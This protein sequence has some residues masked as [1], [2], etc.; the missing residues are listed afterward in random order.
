M[1]KQSVFMIV[2]LC[3]I[4]QISQASQRIFVSGADP[5]QIK[6]LAGK[7]HLDILNYKPARGVDCIADSEAIKSI[8]QS[9]YSIQ[10][11]VPDVEAY[12]TQKL[13]NYKYDFGQYYTY[14]EMVKELNSIHDNY[15][16]ITSPPE[17]IGQTGEGRPIW[18]LKINQRYGHNDLP[19][20]LL[21]GVHHACEPIGCTICMGL[22]KYFCQNYGKDS[23]STWLVNNRNLWF[24]PVVNPD[25]YVFN[26][27]NPD[28]MWR[29]N[30]RDNGG[31][32]HGVDL[33]RN[34]PYMWGYNNR[35]SSPDSSDDIY[36]GPS[37]GSEQETQA[38]MNLAVREGSFVTS[39]HYHA[40]ASNSFGHAW[41]YDNVFNPD[42]ALFYDLSQEIIFLSGYHYEAGTG[43]N[44]DVR[45][46]F[47]GEQS[48]KPKCFAYLVEV[49]NDFWEAVSDTNI[50]IQQ[51]G[52]NLPIALAVAKAAGPFVGMAEKPVIGGGNGNGK[53]DPGETV[54]LW[55]N[56]RNKSLETSVANVSAVLSSDDP[57]LEILQPVA[58]FG[59]LTPR[60]AKTNQD[61]PF[62]VRCD[63]AC[64]GGYIAGLKVKY[65]TDHGRFPADTFSLEIG[66][67]PEEVILN[68]DCESGAG[69][70]S[71]GGNNDQ[72]HVSARDSHTPSHS[73]YSGMEGTGQYKDTMDC[74]LA[75]GALQAT[76]FNKLE[77]WTRYDLEPG[78]DLG[79]AEISTD[80]GTDWQQ[81]GPAYTGNVVWNHQS[82]DLSS[83]Y[84]T[85]N[86]AFRMHSDISV[87][88]YEGWCIDDV[89][90]TGT[91]DTNKAPARPVA[92]MPNKDTVD[93]SRP[94][95]IVGKCGD[96]NGN[97]IHYGFKVYSDSL[98]CTLAASTD[99][100]EADTIWQVSPPL[101]QGRYWWRAY[102]DDGR[103]RGLY[104]APRTFY[105]TNGITPVP[106]KVPTSYKLSRCYPNPAGNLVVITYQ[107]PQ[108]GPLEIKIYN[109]TGQ[110]V[111]RLYEGVQGPGNFSLIWNLK[112]DGGK[113]ILSGIYICQLSSVGYHGFQKITV[114][115][116][117][118][119]G[120]GRP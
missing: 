92:V 81:I 117:G 17:A 15:P 60:Q 62:L 10:I 102:A 25:G 24:V 74:R 99:S 114:L 66:S 54:E 4:F 30:R 68:D 2:F 93:V 7:G 32:E 97:R 11:I 84:G 85:L 50:I 12:Y 118:K 104:S 67:A 28:G 87:H 48:Q 59:S 65:Q 55:A 56:L 90:L 115:R 27:T 5:S 14:A 61:R 19:S 108:K 57:Y 41:S 51:F 89:K 39:I 3:C 76:R 113:G 101:L 58:D 80:G 45:D 94:L 103:L 78:Y 71:H 6:T 1:W 82:L 119:N 23:L 47:Y 73:W 18:A 75:T 31:G 79:Y 29:K 91:S 63:S 107:L 83:Y 42:S 44:G 43:P 9:S 34:Y 112:N 86:I 64:P 111:R 36:R 53:L 37:P 20:V 116:A 95:L 96:P 98:L 88:D 16:T 35:G 110:L 72:W 33:N 120:G 105:N 52:Q 70:W 106:P 49:G 21:T 13:L 40:P 100:S 69:G 38:I 109:V 26:E 46:W 77:F 22:L 8:K